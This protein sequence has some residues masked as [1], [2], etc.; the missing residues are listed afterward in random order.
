MFKLNFPPE[1][2]KRPISLSLLPLL[3][4]FSQKALIFNVLTFPIRE[5][6]FKRYI[7]IL[8]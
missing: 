4:P 7:T 1:L 8:P 2:V 5:I 6:T 3:S